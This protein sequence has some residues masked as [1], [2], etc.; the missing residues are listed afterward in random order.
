[1]IISDLSA[2]DELCQLYWNIS[3][4][5]ILGE[6]LSNSDEWTVSISTQIL[7]G[8]LNLVLPKG[9]IKVIFT[10]HTELASQRATLEHTKC[11]KN[12]KAILRG[13]KHDRAGASCSLSYAP[14]PDDYSN[15]TGKVIPN[16]V[17]NSWEMLEAWRMLLN[18][19]CVMDHH[20]CPALL[21]ILQ[22]TEAQTRALSCK[23][24][25][26]AKKQLFRRL[27][28][29]NHLARAS[30]WLPRAVPGDTGMGTRW[31]RWKSCWSLTSF[32]KKKAT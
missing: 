15:N 9:G 18:H 28:R 23:I 1:M 2:R 10:T 7:K 13:V 16:W 22:M 30:P 14:T 24:K 19:P 27:A 11:F 31:W 8:P 26:S 32:Q 4:N 3:P 20:K 12:I 6:W 29:T 5:H 25:S 17:L 21:D